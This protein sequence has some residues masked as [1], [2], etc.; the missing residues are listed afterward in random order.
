MYKRILVSVENS[1][2]DE[3]ILA[4]V[5]QLARENK[6]SIVLIHVA[7]GWAARNIGPL[8]LR[9]SEE[10]QGDRAYIE[11]VCAALET[12]GLDAEAVLASGDPADEIVEAAEREKCDLIAMATHGHRFFGDLIRGSVANTVRHKSLVP[13]L[14][15][16]GTGP[17]KEQRAK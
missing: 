9:D 10:M 7:D 6:A 2:Y 16:R 17:H 3:A 4:H 14:M 11:N 13:V 8:H 1:S 15:V 12:D 5:R